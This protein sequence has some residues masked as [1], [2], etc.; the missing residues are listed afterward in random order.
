MSDVFITVQK[1]N[2]ANP[3]DELAK[4]MK[5]KHSSFIDLYYKSII[6]KDKH[7]NTSGS[8]VVL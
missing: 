4:L 5:L 7:F 6:F 2:A 3:I 8:G 1:Y